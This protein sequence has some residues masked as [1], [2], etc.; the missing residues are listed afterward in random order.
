MNPT[1]WR[2]TPIDKVLI[3]I[4]SNSDIHD[5]LLFLHIITSLGF[6]D[7]V[8]K[9]WSQGLSL[10]VPL[11]APL[12]WPIPN[13]LLFRES[14]P[15]PSSPIP[16]HLVRWP[17]PLLCFINDHLF[18]HDSQICTSTPDASSHREVTQAPPVEYFQPEL[19]TSNNP[20]PHLR[21]LLSGDARETPAAEAPSFYGGVIL[22]D[23]CSIGSLYPLMASMKPWL[24]N[25]TC[26]SL[27]RLK[28]SVASHCPK[29]KIQI[30]LPPHA[31]KI[32]HDQ[33]LSHT[34]HPNCVLPQPGDH[35]CASLML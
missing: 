31:F 16:C 25:N 2:P 35:G 13:I 19:I 1:K 9:P 12:P 21:Q 23:Y 6:C 30:L 10:P 29:F 14:H 3:W 33:F 15:S 24:P 11:R 34:S 4:L 20:K 7:P 26:D 8:F 28:L 32:L 5:N 17:L 22:L 18:S 27:F